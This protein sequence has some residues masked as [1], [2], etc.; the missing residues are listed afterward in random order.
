MNYNEFFNLTNT[1]ALTGAYLLHGEEEFVKIKAVRAAFEMIPKDMRAFNA[2]TI[3]E[4]SDDAIF[5]ACETLPLFSDKKLVICQGL[6]SGMDNDKLIAYLKNIPDTTV[7]LISLKGK[8]QEKSKLLKFFKDIG[9]EV[10]FSELSE[11]EIIKWCMKFAVDNGVGLDRNTARIL[12]GLVGADMTAISNE[13]KKAIDMA[14]EG[15]V[16]T[17]DIISKCTVGNIEVKVFEMLDC[18]TSGKVKDGMQ[19]LHILLEEEDEALSIAAFLESR[20][21]LMLEGRR[22]MDTGLSAS[23]AA[24]KL[25]GSRYANDKACKAASKYSTQ[26]LSELVR[27]LAGVGYQMMTGGA[28]ASLQLEAIML[29]FDWK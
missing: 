24:S 21:K 20:F 27:K 11:G 15:G 22:L 2:V 16:I 18:F 6:A 1:S 19:L 28:K 4:A 23:A 25:E 12:V 3:T 14:G 7:L 26:Q 8:I 29:S 10:L 17:A 13:L 9:R 5:E